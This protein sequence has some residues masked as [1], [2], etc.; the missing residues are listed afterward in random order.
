MTSE[1]KEE[2]A[3]SWYYN[4]PRP[5]DVEITAYALLT[6]VARDEIAEGRK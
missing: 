1:E 6:R 4:R 3:P 2:D 5:V